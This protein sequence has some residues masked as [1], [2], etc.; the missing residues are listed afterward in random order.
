MNSKRCCITIL[1]RIFVVLLFTSSSVLSPVQAADASYQIK[2]SY[3]FNFL[4]F[5]EFPQE[6]LSKGSTV[7]VFLLGKDYFEDALDEIDGA[8]TANVTIKVLRLD[9]FDE[10]LPLP[11]QCNVALISKSEVE[12]AQNVL[13]SINVHNVLTIADFSPFISYGGMI[14]FFEIEDTVRFKINKDLVKET[15]YRIAAQLV[16]IGVK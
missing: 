2:A 7:L 13:A 4:K 3:I 9:R 5:I 12:L 10:P 8:K 11:K 14:E 15:R 6:D 16:E 1:V